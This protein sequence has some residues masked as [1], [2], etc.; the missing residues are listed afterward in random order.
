MATRDPIFT[1]SAG[2]LALWRDEI[3]RCAESVFFM[4]DTIAP[5]KGR[6]NL[7]LIASALLRVMDN[8][9]T[10]HQNLTK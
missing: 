3:E 5:D 2:N 6:A 8:I 7:I 1:L 9:D 10:H 4:A